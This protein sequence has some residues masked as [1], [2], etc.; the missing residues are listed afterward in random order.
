MAAVLPVPVPIRCERL[1]TALTS[2]LVVGFPLNQ[3]RVAV[4]PFVPALVA[5]ETLLFPFRDLPDFLAAVRAERYV[6][7]IHNRSFHGLRHSAKSVPL[8]VRLD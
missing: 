3:F 4:P 2:G 7:S 8:A 1:S 6:V 5:A